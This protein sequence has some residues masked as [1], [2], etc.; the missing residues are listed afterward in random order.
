M[1]RR[2]SGIED[3]GRRPVRNADGTT[4]T[5]AV[6]LRGKGMRHRARYVD[7]RGGEH[8]KVFSTNGMLSAG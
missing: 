3:R 8:A 5:C 6:P 1:R 7:Y 2:R 4:Q